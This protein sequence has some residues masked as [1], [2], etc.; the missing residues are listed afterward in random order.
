MDGSEHRN[1]SRKEATATAEDG[2][3]TC[4]NLELGEEPL[5]RGAKTWEIH[6]I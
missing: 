4:C 6:Q 5:W 2:R 1:S 3:M